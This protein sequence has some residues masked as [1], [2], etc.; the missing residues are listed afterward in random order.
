MLVSKNLLFGFHVCWGEI[1]ARVIAIQDARLKSLSLH[2]LVR[3]RSIMNT[4]T[5]IQITLNPKLQT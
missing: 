5:S 2:N 4:A 1:V 3:T